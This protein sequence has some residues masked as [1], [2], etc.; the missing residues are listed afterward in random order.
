MTRKPEQPPEPPEHR[1]N[2]YLLRDSIVK[3]LSVYLV[4]AAESGHFDP[5]VVEMNLNA[6]LM[7]ERAWKTDLV[8]ASKNIEEA[9]QQLRAFIKRHPEIQTVLQ[10]WDR[11][12]DS[13]CDII[14]TVFRR[15]FS[16]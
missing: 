14:D 7:A 10:L 15:Y 5:D 1:F 8:K 16:N 6:M 12:A 9:K 3:V 11:D 4:Q 2:Y 13:V